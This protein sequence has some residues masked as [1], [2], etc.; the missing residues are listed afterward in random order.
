MLVT[1]E[2]LVAIDFYSMGKI[3]W[4]SMV[5][6]T[7][8]LQHSSKYLLLCSSTTKTKK[9]IQV[10]KN[11][12][13]SQWWQNCHFWVNYPI[14][15]LAIGLHCFLTLL[16]S[17]V[18]FFNSLLHQNMT[19]GDFCRISYVNNSLSLRRH[20]HGTLAKRPMHM[21]HKSGNTSGV[22]KSSSD[23]LNY[24]G[25]PGDVCVAFFNVPPG[26]KNAVTSNPLTKEESRR[27]Y[28]CDERLSGSNKRWIFKSMWNI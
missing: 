5:T 15:G 9:L 10:W 16:V 24:T 21:A 22:S 26:N 8:W 14:F 7:V 11:M 13:A 12:M 1:K 18:K 4:K 19:L 25:F 2:L 28:N 20:T 23:W 3:L 17:L 6:S 27:V